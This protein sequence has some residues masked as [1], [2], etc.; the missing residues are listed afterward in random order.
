MMDNDPVSVRLRAAL[1]LLLLCLLVP[2][3]AHAEQG[4]STVV[5]KKSEAMARHLRELPNAPARPKQA[6]KPQP[7]KQK[8]QPTP[9]ASAKVD[10]PALVPVDEAE[11]TTGT[12][13]PPKSAR[14]LSPGDSARLF[15][16]DGDAPT[17]EMTTGAVDGQ[18]SDLAR[19]YCVSISGSASDARTAQQM[20]KLADMEK[21]IGRR[22]AALEAKTAEYKSWVERRDEFLKRATTSLVKIY[23][24]MEP[25]AAALQLVSMDEETAAS[26]LMKLDPQGA[27]A[28]LNEM[29]PEKAARLAA[30]ISGAARLPRPNA[31]QQ[32]PPR[33]QPDQDLPAYP[34]REGRS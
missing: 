26:L 24:Q 10:V 18:Q 22:I 28:I 23:S 8:P 34:G 12:V 14:I 25:D 6:A 33:P 2:V 32:A 5:E 11:I 3:S 15:A 29:V 17:S 16:D 31:V 9:V 30:T 21:Q 20:T 4:W 7:P 27:S 19:G 1:P 13:E